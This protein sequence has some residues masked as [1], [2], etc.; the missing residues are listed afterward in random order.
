MSPLK[1][2]VILVFSVAS[3]TAIVVGMKLYDYLITQ[4]YIPSQALMWSTIGG[5]IAGVI[6]I[7]L[8]DSQSSQIFAMTIGLA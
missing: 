4:G 1:E 5:I 8:V 2:K 3:L 6:T 7:Y